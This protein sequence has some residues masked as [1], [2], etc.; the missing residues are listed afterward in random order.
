MDNMEREGGAAYVASCRS[1]LLC[2]WCGV[3]NSS[4]LPQAFMF[5]IGMF[6]PV[7]RS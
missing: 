5:L 1:D 3:Q 2:L 7:R 4:I 6:A